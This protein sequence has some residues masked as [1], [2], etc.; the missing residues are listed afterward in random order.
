VNP[1]STPTNIFQI[2][3][4]V[5][6]VVAAVMAATTR[7]DTNNTLRTRLLSTA[8]ACWLIYA[9]LGMIGELYVPH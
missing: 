4:I 3:L 1:A 9:L 5:A 6:G 8:F 7:N 2:V